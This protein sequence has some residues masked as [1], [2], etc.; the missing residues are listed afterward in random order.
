MLSARHAA[1]N[2][3][4]GVPPGRRN[5][6]AALPDFASQMRT[7]GKAVNQMVNLANSAHQLCAT[8]RRTSWRRIEPVGN[9]LVQLRMDRQPS[10]SAAAGVA[11]LPSG[12]D[13]PSVI[14]IAKSDKYEK[15]HAVIKPSVDD[16]SGG[17]ETGA[18][19][20]RRYALGTIHVSTLRICV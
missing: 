16:K 6:L 3:L 8:F 15:V 20:R 12:P 18:F 14:A 9:F 7:A 19:D 10:G 4:K 2:L 11:F 13:R 1:Q 17:G 5:Y